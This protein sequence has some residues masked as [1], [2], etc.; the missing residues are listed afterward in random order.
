MVYPALRPHRRMAVLH[1]TNNPEPTRLEPN[2]PLNPH[3]NRNNICLTLET[4]LK[5]RGSNREN[6]VTEAVYLGNWQKHTHV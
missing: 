2:H 4:G 3:P 5:K 6:Q 1:S